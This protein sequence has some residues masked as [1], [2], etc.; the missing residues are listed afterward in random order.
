MKA[1]ILLA[2]VLSALLLLA[3]NA[4]AFNMNFLNGLIVDQI[5]NDSSSRR[6]AE[7]PVLD[8]EPELTHRHIVDATVITVAAWLSMVVVSSILL[9][10][11]L[12]AN[13]RHEFSNT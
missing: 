11:A 3:N 5:M 7:E 6:L 9:F 13:H 10:N 12:Y 4:Q 1:I 2:A 8:E